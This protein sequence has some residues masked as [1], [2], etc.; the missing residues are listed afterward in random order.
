MKFTE[1]SN[2][3][4]TNTE[5]DVLVDN[6]VATINPIYDHINE[7]ENKLYNGEYPVAIDWR[8]Q[9]GYLE[10]DPIRM[11]WDRENLTLS[12]AVDYENADNPDLDFS[13]VR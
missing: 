2:L 12:V 6:I 1:P 7:I 4:I 10:D 11:D 3:G 5:M 9:F 8:L 13:F